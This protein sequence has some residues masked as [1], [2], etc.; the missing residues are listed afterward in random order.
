MPAT[1]TLLPRRNVDV[2]V[3]VKSLVVRTR[4][5]TRKWITF[6]MTAHQMRGLASRQSARSYGALNRT[7]LSVYGRRRTLA[8]IPSIATIVCDNPA[9]AENASVLA[10]L[11][12]REERNRVLPSKLIGR[13]QTCQTQIRAIQTYASEGD[14]LLAR[15]QL[16]SGQLGKV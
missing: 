5:S 11:K 3:K 9:V 10:A 13:L 4:Q 1:E 7:V 6:R 12:D 15:G 8:L 2:K 14:Y 16:R